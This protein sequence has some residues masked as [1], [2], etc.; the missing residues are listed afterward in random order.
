MSTPNTKRGVRDK[1][2][3]DKLRAMPDSAIKFTKDA[4]R[5]SPDDWADAIA[6]QGLPPLIKKMDA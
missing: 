5:T 1:T 4:P 6:H 3:W 2:D